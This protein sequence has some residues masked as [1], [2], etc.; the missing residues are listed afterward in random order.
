[1]AKKKRVN[2]KSLKAIKRIK[3]K[4]R[5]RIILNILLMIA[6][7]IVLSISIGGYIIG[8][9]YSPY[10][11]LLEI[12]DI[13]QK[14]TQSFII[15][16]NNDKPLDE[17]TEIVKFDPIQDK[18]KWNI[19]Q[20]YL[21]T[22]IAVEDNSFYTRKTKGYSIK[23][24]L[25]AVVSQVQRKLG[26][27]VVS[28]G[29]STI[30]QQLV[31]LMVFG[32]NNKNSISDKIIQL[33][34]ARKLATKYDRDDILKAYLN[35]LR[36]TPNTVGVKAASI[37]L[38]GNDMSKIDTNDPAQVVQVAFM[39]GLGQ[40]PS[41]YIQD[42]SKSGKVR[43]KTILSIM[44]E[45]ELIN[46]DMYKKALAVVD[47]DKEEF[48]LKSYKQ[49]GTLKEYQAYISKVKDELSQL[50]LPKN[51]TITVKTYADGEQLKE[52]HKI[53]MGT[54]PQDERLPNGYIEHKESLTGISVIDTQTG[55]IIGLA[56]NSDNPLIPYTAT[57]S[58]GST[59]KPLL[60]YAPAV[61]YAGMTP[62]TIQNGSSFTIAD[63]KVKNYGNQNFGKV[64]ASYALGLSINSAAAEAFKMTTDQQKNSMMEP[65]GL[66]SYNPH[67]AS[68]T[69]EQSINYPTNVFALSSAFS[70]FGNDG[71]RVEPTTIKSIQIDSGPIKLAEP[72]R[73]RAMSSSTAKT[74][75]SMLKEVTGSNGSEPYGGPRY[76]GFDQDTYVMKS[77]LSN[78][79]SSVPN[80]S[81]KS[82]DALLAMAS[83]EI[84]IATWIG[85]PGYRDAKYA[86]TS[87][88]HD[89]ANRGRLY[90]M[91]SA[92]KVMMEGRTAKKFEFGN[93]KLI[94]D[95][96]ANRL[97]PN[98]DK[99]ADDDL[100]DVDIENRKI[101]KQ[102]SEKFDSLEKEYN[103]TKDKLD[104][105]YK[106]ED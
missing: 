45:N 63:W 103:K 51:M 9:R 39:A 70:T 25:G 58:S 96:E 40:S 102:E 32:S 31:K 21:D 27:D 92:F 20:L 57:R 85:S 67:G 65:F 80:S 75:V 62:D 12:Q 14:I 34:D 49:K 41:T 64:K 55:H 66:N 61:E 77:G 104:R 90:L 105:T 54:Y 17:N 53:A 3:A 35:E 52:L 28:R 11:S 33:I 29:G 83:P 16:D 5:R 56:T 87:F 76:T 43:T 91:N 72:E 78:F 47:S 42:F 1:M 82:P 18:P 13:D 79:E 44:E 69:A 23:G 26:K 73:K 100:D 36:L 37:E 71:V 24:T 106:G 84:S 19:N 59:I 68:Y 74:M 101:D 99:I 94:H 15:L 86:P 2:Q 88:P 22:I 38:F 8:K 48:T 97:I 50:N 89:T 10:S 30:E 4:R 46:N 7:L 6:L 60:D 81:N 93:E 95:D 98:L